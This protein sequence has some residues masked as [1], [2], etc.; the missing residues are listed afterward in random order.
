MPNDEKLNNV[1][2]PVLKLLEANEFSDAFWA[3]VEIA[4]DLERERLQSLI[5]ESKRAFV[6]KKIKEIPWLEKIVSDHSYI[7]YY[8]ENVDA[9]IFDHLDILQS[10]TEEAILKEEANTQTKEA[11][12]RRLETKPLA[13]DEEIEA[14]TYWESL[15][16]QVAE[17]MIKLNRKGYHTFESGFDS[18]RLGAREQYF[19][20]FKETTPLSAPDSLVQVM[21]GKGITLTVNDSMSDR[22]S[23]ILSSNRKMTLV[24]WKEVWNLVAEI[25]PIRAKSLAEPAIKP[26]VTFMEQFRNKQEKVRRGETVYIGYDFWLENGRVVER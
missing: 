6:L 26:T 13:S 10:F 23:L 9:K 11:L 2:Q 15:E 7:L 22:D 18:D 8:F 14:G 24:D 5:S 1:G 21:K 19:S 4:D 16:P 25:L 20:V 3:S 17:A 12:K